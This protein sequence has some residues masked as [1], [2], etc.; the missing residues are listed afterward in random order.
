MK[1]LKQLDERTRIVAKRFFLPALG[2]V[3]ALQRKKKNR[4]KTTAWVSP[5]VVVNYSD[6]YIQQLL[7]WWEEDVES[8]KKHRKRIS[9]YKLAKDLFKNA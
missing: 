1:T 8:I 4:W 6:T 9:P 7:L 2:S 5:K 3:V